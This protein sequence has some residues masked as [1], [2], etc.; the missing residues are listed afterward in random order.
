M[1]KVPPPWF[2]L[3]FKAN[4][5]RLAE[6]N[7]KRQGF[8]TF[9][10]VQEVNGKRLKFGTTYLRPLFPGYMF[11]SFEKNKTPWHKINN[12]CGV[13]R[14]V[15]FD[16]YPKPIAH[17]FIS[18]LI[19]RCSASGKLLSPEC[20]KKGSRVKL[21]SGPF[22]DFLGKVEEI[23]ANKRIWILLDFMGKKTMAAVKAEKVLVISP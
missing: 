1:H 17:E 22:A 23:D 14:L 18:G 13:S 12:T 6:R 20:L 3:Q 15:S 7:L 2:L 8:K 4:A 5:H 21:V 9:L 16:G 19:S 11:V 10:P